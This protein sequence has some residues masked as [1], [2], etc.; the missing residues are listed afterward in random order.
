MGGP[1]LSGTSLPL[2]HN[3]PAVFPDNAVSAEL[4]IVFSISACPAIAKADLTVPVFALFTIKYGLFFWMK[5]AV[6]FVD[7]GGRSLLKKSCPVKLNPQ[8]Q[9]SVV[10]YP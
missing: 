5:A 10:L 9:W 2:F 6:T 3:F 8:S 1:S 7:H 4:T